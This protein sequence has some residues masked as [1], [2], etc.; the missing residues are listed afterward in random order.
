MRGNLNVNINQSESELQ[1]YGIVY[2]LYLKLKCFNSSLSLNFT[3]IKIGRP[4]KKKNADLND[5]K[6]LATTLF[7]VDVKKKSGNYYRL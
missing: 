2:L 4:A 1:F 3:L 7:L 6:I 5:I